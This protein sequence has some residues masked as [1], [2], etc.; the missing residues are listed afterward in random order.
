MST[1]LPI[2]IKDTEVAQFVW[3]PCDCFRCRDRNKSTCKRNLFQRLFNTCY[4]AEEVRDGR[5]GIGG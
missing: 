2:P 5:Q 3:D 1:F 4:H